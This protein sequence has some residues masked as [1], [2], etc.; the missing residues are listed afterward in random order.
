MRK[1][2][3]ERPGMEFFVGDVRNIEWPDNTFDLALDKSTID[4]LLWG[5]YSF[6]NVA[7]MTKE[8]QRVLKPGGWY[9]AISY[10]NPE[11]RSVHF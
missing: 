1:R 10:G 2:N 9:F 6:T 8:I 11:S 4:A 5:D 7:K 3:T